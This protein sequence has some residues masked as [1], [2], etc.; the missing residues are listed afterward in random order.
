MAK[1]RKPKMSK[2]QR[3]AIKYD[4]T[5]QTNEKGFSKSEI[6]KEEKGGCDAFILISI[7]RTD[8][9]GTSY[10]TVAL[11]GRRKD[12]ELQGR[13]FAGAWGIMAGY[14]AEDPTVAQGIRA[15]AR[16]ALAKM[17]ETVKGVNWN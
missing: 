1:Q 14:I 4:L 15:I 7:I 9:G 12:Q 17:R 2:E 8:G 10:K 13:D 3:Y 6:L 11:D 5:T 16:G